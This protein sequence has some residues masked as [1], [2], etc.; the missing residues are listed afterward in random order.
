MKKL[1]SFT[2]FATIVILV[3]LAKNT[4][5]AQTTGSTTSQSVVAKGPGCSRVE[6]RWAR[7]PHRRIHVRHYGMRWHA[8]PM[9]R[10]RLS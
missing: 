7:I 1:L 9:R 6:N 5:L 2:L 8:R 3:L 10:G 4:S